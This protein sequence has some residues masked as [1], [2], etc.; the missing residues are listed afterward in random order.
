[1]LRVSQWDEGVVNFSA[2][3]SGASTTP[4]YIT[5]T[6][7]GGQASNTARA[8]EL[9]GSYEV[10]AAALLA[11]PTSFLLTNEPAAD[12]SVTMSTNTKPTDS[13]ITYAI[14]ITNAGPQAAQS[15]VLTN[16]LPTRTPFV[17]ATTNA[18]DV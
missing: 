2:P 9:V 3:S 10:I 4:T 6:I 15:L 17:K 14:T 11:A 7:S 5:A 1:M 12:L 18:G 8:D 13:K 16:L